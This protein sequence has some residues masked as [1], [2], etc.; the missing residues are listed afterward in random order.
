MDPKKLVGKTIDVEGKGVGTV[1]S[2]AKKLSPLSDSLHRI[3]FVSGGQQML[4]LHRSKLGKS[5]KG[6]KFKIVK[7]AAES[8]GTSLAQPLPSKTVQPQQPPVASLREDRLAI[9]ASLAAHPEKTGMPPSSLGWVGTRGRAFVVGG[10]EVVLRGVNWF[11]FETETLCP[12]GLWQRPL[13]S[14]LNQI[15]ELP[16]NL[17]RLPFCNDIFSKGAQP[18][19][20]SINTGPGFNPALEGVTCLGL[21][22]LV[23]H[24]CGQRGI[25]VLLD[26]HRPTSSAQSELWY[27]PRSRTKRR[28]PQR[29]EE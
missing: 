2:F 26:R 11:G 4:L 9:A 21:L 5:N 24:G 6:S 17:L 1:L 10:K 28:D 19:A 29:A 3:K 27:N 13:D 20:G 8:A 12:H 15:L 22:D 18:S 16:A 25:R 23:V 14:M 7:N